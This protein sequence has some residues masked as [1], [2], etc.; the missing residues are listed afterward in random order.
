MISSVGSQV[1][2]YQLSFP[3]AGT[4]FQLRPILREN[5]V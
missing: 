1:N 5:L 2:G 3:F 4:L